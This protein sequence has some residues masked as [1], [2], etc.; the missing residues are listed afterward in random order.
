MI[1]KAPKKRKKRVTKVKFSLEKEVLEPKTTFGTTLEQEIQ[2]ISAAKALGF[3]YRCH[4]SWSSA[5]HKECYDW[6]FL[7]ENGHS[8]STIFAKA[9]KKAPEAP[10][11]PFF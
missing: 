1:K 8:N 10:I 11:K 5:T 3:C 9:V 6:A 7:E 2:D 4:Y